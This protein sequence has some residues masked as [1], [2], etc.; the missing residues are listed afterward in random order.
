MTKCL[1]DQTVHFLFCWKFTSCIWFLHA[2]ISRSS[3]TD[4]GLGMICNAFPDT[5]TR[6]LM[7]LCP[8][9]TSCK[10]STYLC[11][12]HPVVSKDFNAHICKYANDFCPLNVQLGS[13][14]LQHN[15]HSF[16]SWTVARAYALTQS[17]KLG[18]R[19]LVISM[20][21]SNSALN[22]RSRKS[23]SLLTRN[24]S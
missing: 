15:C 20:G 11:S 18:D 23:S 14:W 7:A 2:Y 13:R 17:L 5:L 10:A 9:I 1:H 3:I 6:L 22:C 12:F 24:W 19:I 16:D 8:N 4:N 21:G